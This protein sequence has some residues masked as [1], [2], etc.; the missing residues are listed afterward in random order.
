MM[1]SA[2]GVARLRLSKSKSRRDTALHTGF[3]SADPWR[4]LSWWWSLGLLEQRFAEPLPPRFDFRA[5]SDPQGP[6]PRLE[7]VARQRPLIDAM[8]RRTQAASE[9]QPAVAWS[10]ICPG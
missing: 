2:G 1:T 8:R 9:A 3:F 10:R 4:S 5:P 7:P 6:A